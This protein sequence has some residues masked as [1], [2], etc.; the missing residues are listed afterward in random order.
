[1]DQ[2]AE[3]V[4][5]ADAI[6]SDCVGDWPLVARRQLF[7]RWMLRECAVRPVLVVGR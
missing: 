1:V 4:T 6:E 3:Q 7:D 2:P 5:A